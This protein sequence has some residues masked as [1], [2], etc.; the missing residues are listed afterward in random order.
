MKDSMPR[1][2]SFWIHYSR[3][4]SKVGSF[5]LIF[6]FFRFHEYVEVNKTTCSSDN[7]RTKCEWNILKVINVQFQQFIRDCDDDYS[8]CE[9][10][11]NCHHYYYDQ[12]QYWRLVKWYGD[13]DV[14]DDGMGGRS[15]KVERT[16][17]LQIQMLERNKAKVRSIVPILYF[18]VCIVGNRKPNSNEI[19]V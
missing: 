6:S 7:F 18:K 5:N 1:F 19:K 10:A 14:D 3:P 2:I 4:E 15:T 16:S 13:G 9:L 8:D 12:Y 17:G 11:L